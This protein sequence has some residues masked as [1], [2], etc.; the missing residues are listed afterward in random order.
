AMKVKFGTV[1]AAEAARPWQECN[2]APID[3]LT[4]L[5]PYGAKHQPARLRQ[6]PAQGVQRSA[7]AQTRHPT[8]RD[9]AWRST[10]RKG[11]NGGARQHANPSDWVRFGAESENPFRLRI[12]QVFIESKNS[13]FVFVCLSL[14]M[15]NSIASVV[16]IGA[17]IRRRTKIFCRSCFGTRR[18]SLRVPDLR[19]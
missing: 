4:A 17:R 8:D 16:P 3:A 7:R 19:M 13:A 5:I 10:A 1:F 14:S 18:S 12:D 15:R 2:Q 9:P 11:E 6:V